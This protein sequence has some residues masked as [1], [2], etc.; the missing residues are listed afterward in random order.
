MALVKNI[1][2]KSGSHVFF[3]VIL[4]LLGRTS[5]EGGGRKFGEENQYFRTWKWERTSRFM[6]LSTPLG[7]P[8]ST[9]L[10]LD[11]AG[12]RDLEVPGE[13]RVPHA[14]READQPAPRQDNK[15]KSGGVGGGKTSPLRKLNNSTKN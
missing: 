3:P 9:I 5:S 15:K 2:W 10:A 11:G 14:A 7:S 8:R 13:R 12:A 4:G 6:E 1:T